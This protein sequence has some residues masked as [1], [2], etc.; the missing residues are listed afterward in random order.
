MHQIIVHFIDTHVFDFLREYD[1]TS[2]DV[3]SKLTTILGVNS[4]DIR[5]SLNGKVMRDGD[6]VT[7]ATNYHSNDMIVLRA[8][9]RGGLLGGKGG[10]GAM[11]RAQAKK[12]GK[13]I[14]DFSACRDLSG[15]RL[16]HVND[17][18]IMQ[19]W[20]ESKDKGEEFD[21]TQET[22][23]GL[24]MWFLGKPGWVDGNYKPS[25]RKAFMKPRVKSMIC[26]DWQRSVDSRRD[27]KPPAGIYKVKSRDFKK[28]KKTHT[29]TFH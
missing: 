17:E 18:I 3:K 13:K 19:K 28:Y 11:L 27:G 9:H 7:S 23:T 6:I 15:R 8:S 26:K 21:P 5:L 12:A 4:Q 22:S 25:K 10:F 14:T 29:F 24:D 2:R 1:V 16:R 20:R